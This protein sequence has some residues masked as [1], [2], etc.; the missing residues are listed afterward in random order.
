MSRSDLAALAAPEA[1]RLAREYRIAHARLEWGRR[2]KAHPR[3]MPDGWALD[4]DEDETA[5][6]VAL[7]TDLS[8]P[9]SRDH[10]VR[11]GI[12]RDIALWDADAHSLHEATRARAR[13]A[14]V[15]AVGRNWHALRDDAD[16]LRLALLAVGGGGE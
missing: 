8:R 2:T 10:W 15:D 13:M 16:G 11:W 1:E 6:H 4:A 14:L 9:A 7:L 5:A 3:P 12:E